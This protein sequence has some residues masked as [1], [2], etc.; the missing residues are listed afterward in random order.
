MAVAI[1][2]QSNSETG[3]IRIDLFFDTGGPL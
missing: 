3:L 2:G 1:G